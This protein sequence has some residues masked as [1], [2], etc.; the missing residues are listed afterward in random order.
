MRKYLM[1][2]GSNMNLMGFREPVYG[3]VTMAEVEEKLTKMAKEFG[4]EVEFYQSNH[5][6]DIVD[7]MQEAVSYTHLI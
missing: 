5:E 2:N 7:K 3:T 1:I 6:G 4:V